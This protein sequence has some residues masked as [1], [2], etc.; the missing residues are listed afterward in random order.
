M[1][2]TT[3]G[4]EIALQSILRVD[5]ECLAIKG[6]LAGQQEAGRVFFIPFDRIDYLGFQQPLKESEFQEMFSS[7]SFPAAA[8]AAAAAQATEPEQPAAPA[9]PFQGSALVNQRTPAPIKSAV[10]E[11]FRSRSTTSLSLP[12]LPTQE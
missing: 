10:L 3:A 8:P 1:L 2:V 6:R 11:R 12:R 5:G 7:F 4:V 9:P